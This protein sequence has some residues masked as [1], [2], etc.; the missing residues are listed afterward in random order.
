[1]MRMGE[2]L[3]RMPDLA[4][5]D[6]AKAQMRRKTGRYILAR[7]ITA[8][9]IGCKT[10]V[11]EGTQCHLCGLFTDLP[12]LFQLSGP[13]GLPIIDVRGM[14][15]GCLALGRRQRAGDVLVFQHFPE[16]R[17]HRIGFSLAGLDGPGLRQDIAHM[18]RNGHTILAK[19]LLDVCIARAIGG[20]VAPVPVDFR[21]AGLL[22]DSGQDLL[23]I[24]GFDLQRNA[25]I[26]Q[27][28]SQRVETIV[29]PPPGGAAGWA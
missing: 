9:R 3:C 27:V 15:S 26:G 21:Y 20:A 23:R 16:G 8:F 19:H 14:I 6:F 4:W 7:K 1:M 2:S 18:R 5:A 11:E 12:V 17:E 24:A 29:E 22:D 13:T 25:D 10:F 28:P